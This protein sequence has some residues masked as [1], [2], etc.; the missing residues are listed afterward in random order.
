MYYVNSRRKNYDNSF[1]RLL[2]MSICTKG[3]HSTPTINRYQHRASRGNTMP[4][5]SSASEK[6]ATRE[7]YQR[8]RSATAPLGD[9]PC[10][11]DSSVRSDLVSTLETCGLSDT[12]FGVFPKTPKNF[13]LGSLATSQAGNFV[14]R[15]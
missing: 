13:F 15:S 10:S 1:S 2:S 5:G 8:R 12:V 6:R 7:R 9:E 4:A 3:S 14:E 11:H